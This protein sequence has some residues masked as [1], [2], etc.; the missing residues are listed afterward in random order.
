M[1]L[2]GCHVSTAGGVENAPQRG[3]E[4]GCDAMQIFTSN[5]MQWKG[6]SISSESREKFINGLENS[7][8]QQVVAH[9]SYLI[10]LGSP[11][12]EKLKKSR[13]AFLEEIQRSTFL[14][15]PYIIF[16][17]GSHMGKGEDYAL[18][19]IAE[20]LDYSIESR[21]DSKVEFLLENTA[22]Q[23]TNVG[24]SFEHLKIIIDQSKYPDRLGVCYDTCH[25]FTAGYDIVS[26]EASNRTFDEFDRI[27]G[28]D[29]L[30]V[31]HFNDSKRVLGS[32]I[33][34][35]ECLG[36]GQIGWEPFY[37][38]VNDPRFSDLPMIL[39]TPGGDENFAREIAALKRIKNIGDNF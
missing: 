16:H 7:R 21:P 4:L 39:E 8:V 17:P 6:S 25:G 5:Q 22:G 1:P 26:E 30:H 35:H 15:I 33:D 31:F 19:V 28:L 14:E 11:D 20:S 10:N 3:K 12:S 38:L 2:I 9:D 34:R 37:R 23:G 18:K 24:Y 32:R 36:K 29:R 13:K 27:I